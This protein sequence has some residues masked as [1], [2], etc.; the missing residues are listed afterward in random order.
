MNKNISMRKE[1]FIIAFSISVLIGCTSDQENPVNS[2]FKDNRVSFEINFTNYSDNNYFIDEIYA[3]TSSELNLFNKYYGNTV[4]I[5][6]PKYYVKYIEVYISTNT[7]FNPETDIR[8]DAYL[9]LPPRNS[10]Q[11]YPDSLRNNNNIYVGSEESAYFKKL[12]EGTDYLIHKETGYITFLF[13][14]KDQDAIAVSY[15]IENDSPSDNDDIIYGEFISELVNNTKK[16]IVLKL[17]KPRNL[18][19]AYTDAWKLKLKNIYQIEPIVGTI[20]SLDI[21]IFLATQGGKEVDKVNN[22]SLLKLFGFDRLDKYGNGGTDGKFDDLP[23]INYDRISSEIIFPALQPFGKNMPSGLS[24]SLKY[25]A[26]YD[27]LKS[28]LNPNDSFIIKGSYQPK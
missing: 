25:Q 13:T 8:G 10:S 16:S 27:S 3:D 12:N 15:K 17:I 24:D 1:I 28:S 23:G 9:H 19:P 26:I 5:V 2:H 7:Q 20:K 14:P 18:M 21:D 22:I 6:E 11:L 4:P